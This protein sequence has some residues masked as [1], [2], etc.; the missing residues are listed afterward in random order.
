MG[1][2]LQGPEDLR[3]QAEFLKLP[4]AVQTLLIYFV[5]CNCNSLDLFALFEG[6][7]DDQLQNN[8]HNNPLQ[9]GDTQ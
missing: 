7:Y 3:L 4:E 8:M 1:P 6:L 9:V 5:C 2:P